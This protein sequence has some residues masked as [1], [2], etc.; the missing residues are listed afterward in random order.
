MFHAGDG[1]VKIMLR[2]LGRRDVS[3]V[4]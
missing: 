3:P 1:N 2:E 4:K